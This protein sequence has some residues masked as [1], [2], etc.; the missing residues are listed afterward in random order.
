MISG[1]IL[2]KGVASR[3]SISLTGNFL[4]GLVT[5]ASAT[6][7]ANWLGAEEYGRFAFLLVTTL[8]VTRLCDFYIS[9]CFFTLISEQNRSIRYFRVYWLWFLLQLVIS[10]CV[11]WLIFPEALF[12]LI[13]G[14][15]RDQ[16]GII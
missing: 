13:W 9:S 6:Y 2:E 10:V 12:G 11:I 3:I 14:S 4:R 1:I 8:A 5:I 16:L 7:V 15:L